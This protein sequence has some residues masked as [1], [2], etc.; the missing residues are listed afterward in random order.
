MKH[1]EKNERFEQFWKIYPRHEV[2]VKARRAFER[3]NPGDSVLKQMLQW[4]EQAKYSVQWQDKKFI[5]HPATWLNQRRWE[6]DIPP[7]KPQAPKDPAMYVGEPDDRECRI[8]DE[9]RKKLQ[10]I[11]EKRRENDPFSDI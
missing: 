3:I 10:E 9:D 1:Q 8:D 6:D 5:P 7:I 4:I 11:L 2:K